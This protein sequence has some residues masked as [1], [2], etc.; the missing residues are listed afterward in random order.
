LYF[1]H[2]SADWRGSPCGPVLVVDVPQSARVGPGGA[3]AT[4]CNQRHRRLTVEAER[5]GQGRAT[6]RTRIRHQFQ[7]TGWIVAELA[8]HGRVGD[9]GAGRDEV[10]VGQSPVLNQVP[11]AV[12]VAI[13][14]PAAAL[15]TPLKTYQAD[16][17]AV[18]ALVRASSG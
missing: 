4:I 8:E 10:V 14:D 11:R 7:E 3:I 18:L 13:V 6:P 2:R 9:L 16:L 15:V 17:Y 12:K 1:L 5:Y